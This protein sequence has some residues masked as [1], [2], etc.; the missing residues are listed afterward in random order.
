MGRRGSSGTSSASQ[1]TS[2]PAGSRVND[3]SDDRAKHRKGG[4]S[5]EERA[6]ARE[7][8][9]MEEE[10]MDRKLVDVGHRVEAREDAGL[11]SDITHSPGGSRWSE[12]SAEAAAA[13]AAGGDAF[14]ALK[15]AAAAVGAGV[16]DRT[17]EVIAYARREPVAALTAAAGLGFL[18]G[19]ALA[20][21][22]RG[23]VMV[24]ASGES[25]RSPGHRSGG[26]GMARPPVS[27]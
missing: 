22:V 10:T 5:R 16:Q 8:I 11:V 21:A 14:Q 23:R 27:P 25:L 17:D 7:G 9:D 4:D 26:P 13:A 3:E 15:R 18:A 24:G 20:I 1:V 2:S 19:V 6:N 12:G